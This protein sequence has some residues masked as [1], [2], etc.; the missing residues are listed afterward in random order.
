MFNLDCRLPPS[1]FGPTARGLPLANVFSIP[2]EERIT[3]MGKLTGEAEELKGKASEGLGKVTSN[4][5]QQAK[6]KAEE[7]K[8]KAKKAAGKAEDNAREIR[9]KVTD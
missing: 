1:G 6:G 5:G 2:R 3:I 8:G 7:A 4:E 9:E